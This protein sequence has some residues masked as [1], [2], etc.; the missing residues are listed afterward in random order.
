MNK[1]HNSSSELDDC[2]ILITWSTHYLY[3]YN[4]PNTY[5][6]KSDNV[7]ECMQNNYFFPL[8]KGSLA[9]VDNT[10]VNFCQF[11]D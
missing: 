11:K 10:T 5:I 8:F 4:L 1:E 7:E 3:P 9:V 2:F 6:V